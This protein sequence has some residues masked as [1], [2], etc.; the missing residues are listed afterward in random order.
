[1]AKFCPNCN[2]EYAD[3]AAFCAE[4]GSALEAVVVPEPAAEPEPIVA[5]EPEPVAE[6]AP[7]PVVE[8]VAESAP[9]PAPQPQVQYQPQPQ[10]QYQPQYQQPYYQ[11]P[12]YQYQQAPAEKKEE[13]FPAVKTAVYFW[14]NI[15]MAI[16]FV[17][18]ILSIIL[19][20][21]PSNKSL[22]NYAKAY[23]IANLIVVGIGLVILIVSLVLGA[24]LFGLASEAVG[25]AMSGVSGW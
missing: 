6:P 3:E 4:C 14:L 25:P 2:K 8:P 22:K 10:V 13:L 17:G 19:T 5:A 1:M 11:Q 15:A 23:L 7:Q 18:F 16:P 21:A 12:Q 20:C 24:G 9:Q